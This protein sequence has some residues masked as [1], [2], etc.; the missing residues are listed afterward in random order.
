MNIERDISCQKGHITISGDE[1]NALEREKGKNFDPDFI[2]DL[3]KAQDLYCSG[4][5]KKGCQVEK[6]GTARVASEVIGVMQ[7]KIDEIT[8]SWGLEITNSL[9][10]SFI[11]L[12]FLL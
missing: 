1:F 12:S 9:I 3:Q 11:P 7:V 6:A 10:S 4:W 5:C 2:T 8:A